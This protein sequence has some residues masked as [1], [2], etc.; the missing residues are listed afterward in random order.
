[1]QKLRLVQVVTT[2]TTANPNTF[3]VMN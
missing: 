1:M 3:A 2:T